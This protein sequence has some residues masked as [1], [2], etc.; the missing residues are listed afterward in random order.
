[1]GPWSYALTGEAVVLARFGRSRRGWLPIEKE[2]QGLAEK[3]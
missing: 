3:P 2:P 1:M